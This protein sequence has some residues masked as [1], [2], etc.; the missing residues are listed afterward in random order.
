MEASDNRPVHSHGHRAK[1]VGVRPKE[2]TVS[3]ASIHHRHIR[4]AIFSL[5]GGR[6]GRLLQPMRCQEL[7]VVVGIA[8]VRQ[9]LHID[10][11]S[12]VPQLL[13]VEPGA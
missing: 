8:L 10:L 9:L 13:E 4:K 1:R 6:F 2:S 7:V 3:S 5:R 12:G 11:L